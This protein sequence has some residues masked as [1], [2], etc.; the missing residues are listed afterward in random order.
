MSFSTK[1]R[2]SFAFASVVSIAPCAMS[3]CARLRIRASFCSLVRRSARPAL[4]WRMLQIL[5]FVVG[6]VGGG[7]ARGRA[8][9][10]H[11]DA[12]AVLLPAHPEVQALALEQVGDL[13]ERLLPEI[14]DLQDLLL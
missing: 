10:G 9:I 7:A 14:L 4:R 13:L 6:R 11:A 12:V 8:P 1:G 3:C 5:H 2:S